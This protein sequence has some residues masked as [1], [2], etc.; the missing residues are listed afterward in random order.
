M[1]VHP[2]PFGRSCPMLPPPCWTED[3]VVGA[4]VAKLRC[5]VVRQVHILL[6][7]LAGAAGACATQVGRMCRWSFC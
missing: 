7:V 3:L 6:E 4:P 2:R 1:S 5:V